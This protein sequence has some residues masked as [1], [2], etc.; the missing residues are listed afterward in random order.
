MPTTNVRKLPKADDLIAAAHALV[1]DVAIA[2]QDAVGLPQ[3]DTLRGYLNEIAEFPRLVED[4]LAES[5]TV[6][7]RRME[8]APEPPLCYEQL[9]SGEWKDVD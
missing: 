8:L 9:M 3:A 4:A 7:D 6:I 5:S 1:A 2:C